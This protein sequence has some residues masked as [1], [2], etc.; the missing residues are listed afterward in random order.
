[1][2]FEDFWSVQSSYP[3]DINL[4]DLIT[5]NRLRPSGM[6]R[7][8]NYNCSLTE[9]GRLP[10]PSPGIPGAAQDPTKCL[11]KQSITGASIADACRAG[12]LNGGLNEGYL[13]IT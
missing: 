3:I 5:P 2:V 11:H 9:Y 12:T 1:M 4:S 10:V 13:V 6:F 7:L 8:N